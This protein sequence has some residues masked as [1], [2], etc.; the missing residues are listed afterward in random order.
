MP[1]WRASRDV[2]IK[3]AGE[4]EVGRSNGVLHGD[5]GRP[6]AASRVTNVSRRPAALPL[7]PSPLVD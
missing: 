5:R 6:V 4:R 2:L 3:L 7:P 1:A